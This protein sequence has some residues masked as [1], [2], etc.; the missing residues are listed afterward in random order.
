MFM[1]T[2]KYTFW[3][4]NFICSKNRTVTK[5]IS[6]QVKE[7]I[8]LPPTR[9]S[10]PESQE[11][12]GLTAVGWAALYKS[13]DIHSSAP[14]VFQLFWPSHD[15]WVL[16]FPAQA[17]CV[18][19]TSWAIVCDTSGQVS[20]PATDSSGCSFTARRCEGNPTRAGGFLLLLRMSQCGTRGLQQA[21]L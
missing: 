3:K 21:C 10:K 17:P 1:G 12:W 6:A 7:K 8:C 14:S 16:T 20:A 11:L 13:W 18:R 19:L 9:L 2:Y 5:K 15:G 4:G